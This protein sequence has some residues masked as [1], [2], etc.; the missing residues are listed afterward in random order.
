MKD[1]AGAP[2]DEAIRRALVQVGAG[3][4]DLASVTRPLL[5]ALRSVTGLESAY[6]TAVDWDR[7]VQRIEIAENAGTLAI[8]EGLEVPWSDTLCRRA[9]ESGQHVTEDVPG[10]WGDSGA[11]RDLGIQTYVSVPVVLPDGAVFGT[12]CGASSSRVHVDAET[13]SLLAVFGRIIAD[14][15]VR[16][17]QLDEANE[18]VGEADRLLRARSEF[19]AAAQ[20]RLKTPLT[21]ILGW[22]SL[23]VEDDGTMEEEDRQTA[24]QAIARAASHATA[25]VRSM[26][27]ESEA[28]A[29]ALDVSVGPVDV[30]EIA[31]RCAKDL[32]ALSAAH[33]LEVVVDPEAPH[34]HSDPE[35]VR[36]VLEHLIENAVKY[37]PDGGDVRID[38]GRSDAGRVRI[39]VCDAGIGLPSGVDIFAPFTRGVDRDVI[40]GSGLGLHVVQSLVHAVSGE[41]TA[42]RNTH[43]PGSTLTVLLPRAAAS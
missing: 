13:E 42:R 27:S 14:A 40:P 6:L 18:R 24:L 17:Q 33:R 8:E 29:L 30:G 5:D 26:L 2:T 7:Q 23:L 22:A 28:A 38:V 32:G 3:D 12:I 15:V 21:V 25:E 36:I 10:T 43:G 34:A 41:V 19:V 16:G 9:L 1:Q 4:G 35:V 31:R 39:A 20:H 37:S 11:A